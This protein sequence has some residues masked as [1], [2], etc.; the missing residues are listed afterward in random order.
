[1]FYMARP[2]RARKRAAKGKIT[3]TC[4]KC[5]AA[6][7]AGAVCGATSIVAA[8]P[9]QAAPQPSPAV[10]KAY[11]V[12]IESLSYVPLAEMEPGWRG[13]VPVGRFDDHDQP[14]SDSTIYTGGIFAG[15]TASTFN[16]PPV[17][18]GGL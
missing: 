14:E 5:G 2:K 13:R 17:E 12:T 3:R 8:G 11:P 6:V 7:A 16:P 18:P 4:G 9:A 15:G 10:V 1:M